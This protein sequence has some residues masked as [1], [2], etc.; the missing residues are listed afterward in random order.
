MGVP[1]GESAI[2]DALATA[3]IPHGWLARGKKI[4]RLIDG[5]THIVRPDIVKTKSG[6]EGTAQ[7]GVRHDQLESVVSSWLK[8][9]GQ[10]TTTEA[11]TVGIELGNLA[12]TGRLRLDPLEKGSA[13]KIADMVASIGLPWMKA[14]SHL[15]I[16]IEQWTS[17]S[18]KRWHQSPVGCA[19]RLPIA[20]H[21]AGRVAECKQSVQSAP[22]ELL[23]AA[24]ASLVQNFRGLFDYLEDLAK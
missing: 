12:G 8:S 5:T 13:Q 14:Q 16:L 24:P 17:P 4:I 19:I 22:P 11:A 21:L 23:Q 9:I 2:L 6:L 15:S 7:L 20:L 1:Q 3:L 10:E 18:F